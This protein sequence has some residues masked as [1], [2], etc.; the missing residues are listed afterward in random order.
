[1]NFKNIYNYI[2]KPHHLLKSHQNHRITI[3]RQNFYHL[4]QYCILA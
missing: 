1:M 3:N 2:K 4:Y